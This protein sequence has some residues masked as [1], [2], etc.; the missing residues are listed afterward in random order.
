MSDDLR[1]M[2][3]S[4]MDGD[5]EEDVTPTEAETPT[6]PV[7]VVEADAPTEPE[8]R[9]KEPVEPED[10]GKPDIAAPATWNK[11]EKEWFYA[12]PVEA[13]KAISRRAADVEKMY[14]T[15]SQEISDR[16]KRVAGFEEVLKPVQDGLKRAGVSE[17]E[18]V[19][20]LIKA[21]Q[22]LQQNPV[23]AIKYLAQQ[24][25]VDLTNL[26]G[27]AEPGVDP[28]VAALMQKVQS[29]EGS[30]GQMQQRE[31]HERS[32]LLTDQITAFENA[33]DDNGNA[34]HP[35]F[36]NVR[37]VMAAFLQSGHAQ[38]LDTAYDMAVHADPSIRQYIAD[39]VAAREQAR[40]S[41][42]A[43]EKRDKAV[44]VTGS[45]GPGIPA[46]IPASSIREELNRQFE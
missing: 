39:D 20:R 42:E 29:L 27:E 36:N 5:E 25:G 11:E 23:E 1:E 28:S 16:E 9:K 44:S 14:G 18:Y 6:E 34:K 7:E 30:L 45:P 22:M 13:Q 10:Q 2:L 8:D 12:Q 15:R 40:R 19:S 46:D 35:H 31:V 32:T 33:T 37:D 26:S 21:D 4:A 17:P 38:D 41:R 24:A 43:E 3:N